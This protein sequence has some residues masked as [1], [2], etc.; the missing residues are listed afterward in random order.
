M[1]STCLQRRGGSEVTDALFMFIFIAWT[2]LGYLGAGLWYG[3][4]Q[5]RYS[6]I[7]SYHWEEDSMYSMFL[8]PLGPLGILLG[9]VLCG[10]HGYGWKAPWTE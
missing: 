7:S 8:V 6:A 9:W 1:F 5:C 4:F 10:R 3:Y 2:L